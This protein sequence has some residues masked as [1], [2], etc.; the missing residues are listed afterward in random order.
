MFQSV[1]LKSSH[2]MW[3]SS[4]KA[5]LSNKWCINPPFS[6]CYMILMFHKTEIT[7][8][9][10]IKYCFCEVTNIKFFCVKLFMHVLFFYFKF[11]H[12]ESAQNF[13]SH[14]EKFVLL[15][16]FIYIYPE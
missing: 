14:V 2:G 7:I 6:D 11:F 5:E 4:F 13:L 16:D 15:A 12:E 10:S 9:D 1:Q 8:Y 3:V